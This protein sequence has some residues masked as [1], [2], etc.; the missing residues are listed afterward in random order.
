M[1]SASSEK[2]WIAPVGLSTPSS[3]KA[4]VAKGARSRF[5]PPAT[6]AVASPARRAR[7]A[8]WIAT[9]DDEHAVSIATDGPRKS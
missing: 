5:T 2:A 4:T 7:T 3:E 6:A 1:P 9:R 8:S